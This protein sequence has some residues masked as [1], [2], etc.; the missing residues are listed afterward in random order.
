MRLRSGLTVRAVECGPRDGAQVVLLPGWGVSAFTFR[1]QLP[2]LGTAGYRATSVD[3]KGHGFSDKPTGRGEYTLAAMVRHV[4]DVIEAIGRRPAIII[5][6]SLAGRLA[7]ELALAR[8]GTVAALVLVSPVGIGVIPFIGLAQLVTPPILDAIAPH[9]ARRWVVHV[10]LGLAYGR[11][12]RVTEDTVDEYWA[13]AQFPGFARA[14]RGLAH[15]FDWS[16]LSDEQLSALTVPTL[17]IRGSLDRLVRGPPRRPAAL[18]SARLCVID[19][20]GHALNEERPEPVN[21][22]ILEFLASLPQ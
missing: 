10:G 7:V 2:A 15:D 12:A 13:P 6:Q 21:A 17:V 8:S 5:G 4:E 1:D 19:D 16:Q 20:A 22:A 3:L 11:R 14:L 18:G 9:L